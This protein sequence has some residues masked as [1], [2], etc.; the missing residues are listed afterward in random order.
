VFKNTALVLHRV[1]SALIM[2]LRRTKHPM[3]IREIADLVRAQLND[4]KEHTVP[5]IVDETIQL[6]GAKMV[7]VKASD[8]QSVVFGLVQSRQIEM[9]D[10]FKVRLPN[11]RA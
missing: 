3:P 4:Q 7:E 1:I 11:D 6:A 9:T 2:L 8:V 5:Q 10:D